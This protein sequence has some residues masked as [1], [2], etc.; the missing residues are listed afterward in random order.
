MNNKQAL[1][2]IVTFLGLSLF[3][4]VWLWL[5][6]SIRC[7]RGELTFYSCHPQDGCICLMDDGHYMRPPNASSVW[8]VLRAGEDPKGDIDGY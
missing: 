5:N 2:G 6:C 7:G 1:F 4:G 3:M 8:D